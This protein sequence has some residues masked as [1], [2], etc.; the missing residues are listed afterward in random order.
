MI[1][2][3]HYSSPIGQVV[4]GTPTGQTSPVEAICTSSFVVVG[5]V[6]PSDFFQRRS[7]KS[8]WMW[9]NATNLWTKSHKYGISMVCL[10]VLRLSMM[11]DLKFKL[12]NP[13]Y[14]WKSSAWNFLILTSN[15]LFNSVSTHTRD[16]PDLRVSRWDHGWPFC[17]RREHPSGSLYRIITILWWIK[18]WGVGLSGVILLYNNFMGIAGDI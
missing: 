16:T 11:V 13:S 10:R 12:I 2:P 6:S 5:V 4:A 1:N 15:G 3:F 9:E 7:Q 18:M 17:L 14:S 8:W